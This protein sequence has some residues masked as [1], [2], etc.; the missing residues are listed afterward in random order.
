MI[1]LIIAKEESPLM[2][3]KLVVNQK[4][5]HHLENL[6]FIQGAN[7]EIISKSKGNVILKIKDGRLAIGE[8]L[9]R[10]IFVE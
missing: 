9:A 3:T 7:I 6:G 2:I 10:K 1:P 5:K 8:D 4:T